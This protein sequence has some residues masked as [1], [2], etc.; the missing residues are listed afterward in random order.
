[1]GIQDLALGHGQGQKPGCHENIQMYGRRPWRC[2]GNRRIEVKSRPESLPCARM[3]IDMRSWRVNC[4]VRVEDK[5]KKAKYDAVQV[6]GKSQGM[7]LN[8][9]VVG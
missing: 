4:T 9:H 5:H 2:Y 6:L 1:M 7:Y 8:F 3:A